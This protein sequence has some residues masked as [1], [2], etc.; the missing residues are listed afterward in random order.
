MLKQRLLRAAALIAVAGPAAA[1]RPWLVPSATT[2]SGTDDWVTVDA[3]VSNDLFYPDHF[4][5]STDGIK[6][7]AP[8]GSTGQIENAAK[9]R[10]RSTFDVHLD[11]PGT[12]KIGTED[13]NVGG[14]FK[15][16]GED[17]AVGRRRGPPPGASAGAGAGAGRE[18]PAGAAMPPRAQAAGGAEGPGGPGGRIP[19]AHSVATLAEI[20]AGATDLKLTETISRNAI[21][22]TAG[23]PTQAVFK[24]SNKGLEMVP[25]TH[26]DE[27]VSNEPARFRFLIDGKPA[28][29]LKV[30]VVP[31]GKRYRDSEGAQ[32]LTTGADG[33]LTIRWPFA[34]MYWLNVTA[35]DNHPS[36]PRA[37]QRRMSYTST[38]EVLAP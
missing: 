18:R 11:K 3:A 30:T 16:N 31:G 32:D 6:V 25:V 33:V 26:P 2:F 24:P 10:Y 7:W 22:V 28:G 20:P 15:V 13:V 19:P 23:A 29:A 8:D 38:L 27:L 5:M 35:S 14:T 1:H 17:W 37:T 12:W 21:F 9:G 36:S 4:P 34:G